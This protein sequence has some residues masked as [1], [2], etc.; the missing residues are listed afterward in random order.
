M[1]INVCELDKK[2]NA[3]KNISA[4]QSVKNI[5]RHILKKIDETFP[6]KEFFEWVN[7]DS[8]KPFKH[9]RNSYYWKQ[10]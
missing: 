10:I 4:E 7:S 2:I 3:E 9:N 8:E 6:E 5:A 1:R